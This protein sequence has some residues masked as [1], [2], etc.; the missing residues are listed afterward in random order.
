MAV[1]G[2]DFP[3]TPSSYINVSE[4]CI[5]KEYIIIWYNFQACC[6]AGSRIRTFKASLVCHQ[7][8]GS[9]DILLLVQILSELAST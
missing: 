5:D 7:T 4:W 2:V 3:V 6:F 9:G 1:M 8:K